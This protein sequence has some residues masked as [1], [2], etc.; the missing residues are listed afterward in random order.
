MNKPTLFLSTVLILCLWTG[1]QDKAALAEFDALKAQIELEN[2][3]KALVNRY[4][5]TFNTGNYEAL[6]ELLSPDYAVYSPSGYPEP[7]S[8]ETLIENYKGASE[9]FPEFT[10]RIEDIVAAED[11]VVMRIIAK[12]NYK[13]D[14]PGLP[15]T[16]KEIEFS[17]ISILRIR[18]GKI[19]EEWQEDDQLGFVRQLGMELKPVEEKIDK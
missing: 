5:E 18:N 4:V 10:W 14:V 12:V 1:C 6:T 2:Q 16:S 19:I 15:K 11:K 7:S 9:A 13:G 3:N 8:R 17:M